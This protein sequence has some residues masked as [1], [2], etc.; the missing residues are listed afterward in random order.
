MALLV[1]VMGIPVV[2]VAGYYSWLVTFRA[3][4]SVM[5]VPEDQKNTL[6][7]FAG[8]AVPFIFAGAVVLHNSRNSPQ[9]HLDRSITRPAYTTKQ[10]LVGS[11]RMIAISSAIWCFSAVTGAIVGSAMGSISP[12][13]ADIYF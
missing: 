10:F 9:P 8:A 3:T 12:K 11:R 5:K 4:R 7:A 6:G 13:E 2:V 1:P